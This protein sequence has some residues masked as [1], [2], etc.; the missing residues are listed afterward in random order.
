MTPGE[1]GV[2]GQFKAKRE[3]VYSSGWEGRL[4]GY[5]VEGRTA[6]AEALGAKGLCALGLCLSPTSASLCFSL[7]L[8]LIPHLHQPSAQARPESL[9]S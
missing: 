2:M 4:I 1:G 8:V 5:G 6:V 3:L 9:K 7:G